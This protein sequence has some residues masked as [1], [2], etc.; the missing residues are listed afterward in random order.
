MVAARTRADLADDL[1]WWMSRRVGRRVQDERI[2]SVE[3]AITE[4]CRPEP[5]DYVH[6]ETKRKVRT[7]MARDR[8]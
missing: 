4:W 2:T 1:E 5:V 8:V 3:T 7:R 6:P